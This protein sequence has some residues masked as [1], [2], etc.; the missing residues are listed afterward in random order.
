MNVVT[1]GVRNAFRNSVR[2]GSIVIILGL[3]IGLAI[4]MLAARQAV[5]NKIES[6]KSSVGTTINISPAGFHGFEGGG[7]P[8]TADELSKVAATTHVTSVTQM[9]T[10]RLTSDNTNLESAIEAG[11]LGQRFGGG[12]AP[13][14]T[15]T[16]SSSNATETRSFTPPVQVTG[17]NDVSTTAA[18]EG[19]TASITSGE[20][21]DAT[22]NTNVALVGK[23]LAEKN[24]LS[25]GSTFTMYG[26]TITVQGIYDTGTTFGNNTV[27][28]P[29][30]T[31]QR[32]SDQSGS[33]TSAVATVD[34]VD[35]LASTTSAIESTLGDSADVTN[36]Q[37]TADQTIE[38]LQ[39]VK[40][41]SLFSLIGALVAGAVIILLTMM[42]IVRERR[43]EIG[44]MKAIGAS[45]L[46][47]MSQFVAESITL[48]VLGLVVG[49]L[50]GIAAASPVTNT[51]VTNSSSSSSS[52]Q[53]F[54]G[55][56]SGSTSTRPSGGPGLRQFGRTSS[57]TLKNIQTSVG[58]STLTAGIGAALFIAIVGSAV[59]SFLI[60][61]IKPA[62][63][64][65]S[66]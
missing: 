27:V 28:V 61:K 25:V 49:T 53:A 32:L 21:I 46:K 40:N 10:D 5:N 4:A 24:S 6:V 66:E 2:T 1:R 37:D 11:S 33:V 19:A 38:P 59:P 30:A 35:N 18:F 65:R 57:E 43:R 64:M 47:I 23:A 29:L 52:S 16:S 41:I 20:S 13:A 39:S 45:N 42:M 12:D 26:E 7:T 34:S 22:S 9:L 50:I 63:A 51:L 55:N 8:L 31:L 36:S 60:S 58:V 44:V 56:T 14:N 17:T 54:G 48:T 3:S 62:E 15:N